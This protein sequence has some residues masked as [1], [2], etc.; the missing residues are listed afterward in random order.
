MD[1]NFEAANQEKRFT[2]LPAFIRR[3]TAGPGGEAFLIDC[4]DRAALHDTG[5]CCFGPDLVRN[6]EGVLADWGYDRLDTVLLSHTHYDHMGALPYVLRRYPSAVVV[7][8]EKAARVFRSQGAL[9]TIRRLG[10]GARALYFGP[11]AKEPE[12]LTDGFRVDHICQDGEVLQ[13][14]EKSFRCLYTPGHTDC[15]FTYHLFPDD[16]MFTS[17]STGVLH[18]SGFI[19]NAILKSYD[20]GVASARKCQTAH[21]AHLIGIHYGWVPAEI[22]PVYFDRFLDQVDREARLIMD[23]YKAGNGYEEIAAAYERRLLTPERAKVQPPEAFRENMPH[24]IR[25]I[26]LKFAGVDIFDG[27]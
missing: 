19:E 23:L 13:L 7:G 20:D 26:L 8:A 14:G 2:D 12:I 11:G 4:G 15:S 22:V 3:V 18:P 27:R 16:I 24:I 17:E 9:Q 5:M 10:E 6:I 25:A 1:R 21:P